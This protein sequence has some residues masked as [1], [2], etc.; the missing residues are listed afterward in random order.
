[1]TP[2]HDQHLHAAAA[3]TVTLGGDLT[4][5]RM[6][7][8]A[9]RLPGPGVWGEP[10]DPA[11][12]RAVLRRA[13]DL[14]VNYF[15]TAAYY[16]PEVANR[17]LREAFYPYPQ[18]LVIGT[19][20]GARRE[21]DQSW[22]PDLQPARLRAGIE[23]NLRQLSLERLDLVHLRYMGDAGVPFLECLGAL[24]DLRREGKV[25][26]IGLSNVSA[27]QLAEAQQLVPIASVQ[28]L[29]N[30]AD[31][32]AEDV[33]AACT[34]QGIVFMPFFPLAIG[35]LAGEQ[36]ELAAIARKYQATPAQVALAWLLRHSPQM[37]VIPGTGSLAHLEENIAAAGIRLAEADYAALTQ[38][39]MRLH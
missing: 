18:G 2:D 12:A 21:A 34:Q 25:R 33:L 19:K 30:L 37:L 27:A 8:G 29:Y 35:K 15:D 9:M 39:A 36:A 32:R 38:S 13:V 23:D 11:G 5:Q 16:G 4:L 17:L 3:G 6:G 20:L 10:A 31:R 7:Y 26:H 28:N 1:M 14:G 24:I 22:K